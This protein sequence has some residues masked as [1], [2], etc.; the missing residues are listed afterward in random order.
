MGNILTSACSTGSF[1][2]KLLLSVNRSFAY[3]RSPCIILLPLSTKFLLVKGD[4]DS[5]NSV[6]ISY[7][8]IHDQSTFKVDI[9]PLHCNI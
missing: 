6:G 3:G 9:I 5:R 1:L 2:Y 4:P 7:D 8:R